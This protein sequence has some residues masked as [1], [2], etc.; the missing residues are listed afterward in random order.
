V[1]NC[2]AMLR[3]AYS[4]RALLLLLML[5]LLAD[6]VGVNYLNISWARYFSLVRVHL[7]SE[8][9]CLRAVCFWLSQGYRRQSCFSNPSFLRRSSR[10]LIC[11]AVLVA[12]PLT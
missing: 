6:G 5:R 1:T 2:K 8:R 3:H 9:L 7:T 12:Q 10:L 11:G 4:R